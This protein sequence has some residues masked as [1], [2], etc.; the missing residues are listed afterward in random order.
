MCFGWMRSPVQAD[1]V[2]YVFSSPKVSGTTETLTRA[3]A[4]YAIRWLQCLHVLPPLLPCHTWWRPGRPYVFIIIF[5]FPCALICWVVHRNTQRPAQQSLRNCEKMD[6]TRSVE[7]KPKRLS[8][9]QTSNQRSIQERTAVSVQKLYSADRLVGAVEN[10]S[11]DTTA[12]TYKN[13]Q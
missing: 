6:D 13:N 2:A 11:F 8:Y 10:R 9:N 5:C 3:I 4:L 12:Y 7:I 1:A